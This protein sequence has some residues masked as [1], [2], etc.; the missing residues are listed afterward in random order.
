ML[1]S[2]LTEAGHDVV[3]VR[4]RELASAADE[5]VLTLAADENRVLISADTDFGTL[6]A[7]SGVIQTVRTSTMA[8]SMRSRNRPPRAQHH[9]S[10]LRSILR[11]ESTRR[12]GGRWL[13]R[14]SRVLWFRR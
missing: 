9:A 6:L 10:A 7:R 5:V 14:C 12:R 1:S 8:G 4:V 3:H 13:R 11:S 2:F